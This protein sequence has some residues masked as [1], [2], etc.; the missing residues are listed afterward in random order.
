MLVIALFAVF[1]SLL[2]PR[3]IFYESQFN[4]A[5]LYPEKFELIIGTGTHFGLSDL[6]TYTIHSEIK[7]YRISATSF[8][9]DIYRENTV[10][11]G[12]SFP[13][14]EKL[15]A[16]FSIA[17]YNY[18]VKDI[19]NRFTYSLKVG[20]MYRNN[21]LEIGGWVN[22]I[23]IPKFSDI[24]YLPPTYSLKLKY[25]TKTNFSF[26]FA[27]RGRETDLPFYNVSLSYSPYKIITFGAGVNT[28]PMY[29]EY[30][31]RLDLGNFILDYTG[32]NHRYLGLSHY[33]S[34]GFNP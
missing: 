18:W 5:S 11:A 29:F 27:I 30:M 12:L 34:V 17:M 15:A 31:L 25:L 32:S 4:P 16:G 33:F 20:G 6:R 21:L 23:N 13:V 22:N 28:E 14:V 10:N 1:E 26:A 3:S 8:G 7:L 24:D 2:F 9:N 19:Y